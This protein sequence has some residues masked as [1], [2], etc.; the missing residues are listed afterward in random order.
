MFQ[1]NTNAP[2]IRI[3]VIL[4][5]LTSEFASGANLRPQKRQRI[6]PLE[7]R[8]SRFVPTADELEYILET[9]KSNISAAHPMFYSLEYPNELIQGKSPLFSAVLDGNLDWAKLLME[10]GAR[11]DGINNDALAVA[12]ENKNLTEATEI[13]YE[14][15]S[16]ERSGYVANSNELPQAHNNS[17]TDACLNENTQEDLNAACCLL[18]IYSR[19]S[20]IPQS[21]VSSGSLLGGDLHELQAN[22]PEALDEGNDSEM[23]LAAPRVKNIPV[24]EYGQPFT[25]DKIVV[26]GR[27]P[28]EWNDSFRNQAIK[29]YFEWL[30]QNQELRSS[31]DA[32]WSFFNE[33][34]EGK[35]FLMLEIKSRRQY[36]CERANAELSSDIWERFYMYCQK[37][38]ESII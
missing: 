9:A 14:I 7:H 36:I 30:S 6:A 11:V 31:V 25:N 33:S 32:V 16:D 22:N 3:F 5:F 37:Y 34:P 28:S 21:D 23:E 20:L 18:S 24:N 29:A 15:R 27:I 12:V 2:I 19:E 4:I 26:L 10:R 35:E 13:L 17:R 8:F 1:T 38:D